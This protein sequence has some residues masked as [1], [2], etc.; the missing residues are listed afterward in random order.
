MRWLLT[1]GAY[2]VSLVVVALL[3]LG[4]ALVV[5]GPH[6]GL[7]PAWLEP[8]VLALAWLVVLAVPPW[9]AHKVW[10][11]LGARLRNEPPA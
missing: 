1:L 11:R 2:L 6:A 5:A 10:V 3:A 4:A 9:L 8:V 7:L